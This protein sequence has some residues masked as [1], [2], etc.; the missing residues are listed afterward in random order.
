M[1]LFFHVASVDYG[2]GFPPLGLSST[3]HLET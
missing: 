2:R 1:G 3:Y